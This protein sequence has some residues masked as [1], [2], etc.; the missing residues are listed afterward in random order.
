MWTDATRR[1]APPSFHWPRS[2]RG[3]REAERAREGICPTIKT[4]PSK[5]EVDSVGR[6][7][8]HLP[9]PQEILL[10]SVTVTYFACSHNLGR[11]EDA[12]I[13]ATPGNVHEKAMAVAV[14]KEEGT[15]HQLVDLEHRCPS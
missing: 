15:H 3:G 1:D 2:R 10:R 9:E 13:S 6:T 4:I 11:E 14:V 12:L 8:T 5:K 7:R